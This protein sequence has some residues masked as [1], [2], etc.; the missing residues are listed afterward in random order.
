MAT[1]SSGQQSLGYGR[2]ERLFAGGRVETP[3]GASRP[4][5]FPASAAG[6]DLREVVL[7]REGRLGILTEATVRVSPLPGAGGGSRR[8]PSRPPDGVEAVARAGR[9]AAATLDDPPLDTGG[10]EDDARARRSRAAR[11]GALRSTSRSGARGRRSA[12]SSSGSPGAR[13][14]CAGRAGRRSGRSRCGAGVSAGT[15]FGNEWQRNRFRAP[16]LRNAL[17]EAGWAVDTLETAAPWSRR[18]GPPGVASRPLSG[19]ASRR[20]REGPRLHAPFSRLPRWLEPLHDVPLPARRR[21][22]RDA[23]PLAGAQD[24]GRR[25]DRRGGRDDQPPARRRDGPCAVARGR[26]G[27]AGVRVLRARLAGRSTRRPDEPREARRRGGRRSRGARIGPAFASRGTWSSSAGGSPAPGSAARR[28]AGPRGPPR[29]AGGLRLGDVEPLV[30]ARSRR[31]P[32]PRE[33]KLRLTCESVR[34]RDRLLAEGPGLVEPIGFLLADLPRRLIRAAARTA[35][36]LVVY[37]LLAGD[38]VTP[39]LNRESFGS[40]RPASLRRRPRR[41]LR[42]RR[43]ATDDAR[44]VLRVLVEAVAAGAPRSTTPVE[45]LLIRDGGVAGVALKTGSARGPRVRAGAVVNATGAWADRLRGEAARRRSG[46]CAA[47][48]SSSP[49]GASRW[50]RR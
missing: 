19:T 48:I 3:A 29:R 25:R 2:I 9:G 17:W 12:C 23:R 26:E 11:E 35:R 8:L 30:E 1:R 24:G 27:G 44:L 4:A 14:S 40:S 28:R 32:L 39:P 16:Y 43:R 20:R 15:A 45:E 50:R 31:A 47:A 10:D 34:E 38:G 6:P 18:P 46:R 13:T 36:G 21:S 49:R 37:D 22:R 41:G 33:G 5:A 7:G 42:L